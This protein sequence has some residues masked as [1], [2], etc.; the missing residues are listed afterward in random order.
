M[1]DP[2]LFLSYT[3]SDEK[4][5]L[6]LASDLKNS[7]T[8]VWID[9]MDIPPG[10]RW[11]TE[12]EKALKNAPGII[13]IL[14]PASVGSHN[15]MDEISYA[16]DERKQV[17]P[18]LAESCQIPF[19]IRR[20]Q[21]VDFTKSYD[22]GLRKL[23]SKLNPGS[24]PFQSGSDSNKFLSFVKSRTFLYVLIGIIVILATIFITKGV[25][26]KK[27]DIKNRITSEGDT[28]R[29]ITTDTSIN[30]KDTQDKNTSGTDKE[31]QPK[32]DSP[33]PDNTGELSFQNGMTAINAGNYEKAINDFTAAME[34]NY[35]KPEALFLRGRCY[36]S[37]NKLNN[38]CNDYRLSADLGH[39]A[40]HSAYTKYCDTLKTA[41][42]IANNIT[43]ASARVRDHRNNT[44][45]CRFLLKGDNKYLNSIQ[46]V[47]YDI[48]INNVLRSLTSA[49]RSTGFTVR[50][51]NTTLCSGTIYISIISKKDPGTPVK[52]RKNI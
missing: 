18:V 14:T 47:R 21:Y 24:A 22:E 16:L 9:Q 42:E 37:L 28:A 39:E 4:L 40:G 20:L 27:S 51:P 10:S 15:V 46:Q 12:V 49:D 25:V 1:P 33:K 6:K 26:N 11:D 29:P 32:T 3:R 19:R 45:Y 7:G 41:L 13:V 30:P 31:T 38:A 36:Q 44:N 17:I 52:V 35:K 5:A 43:V 8:N 23:I 48:T 2:L 50:Y 34:K